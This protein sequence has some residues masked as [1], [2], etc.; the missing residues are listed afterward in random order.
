MQSISVL[1]I[2]VLAFSC[3]LTH[4][5]T[6]DQQWNLWKDEHNKHYSNAEE[7]IRYEILFF[8]SIS[9]WSLN[10]EIVVVLS[11]KII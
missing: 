11:G 7:H 4:D 1:T 2:V 3:T 6:L 5:M 9:D 10:F 8:I